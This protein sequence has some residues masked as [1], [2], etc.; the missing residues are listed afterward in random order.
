[1]S[2]NIPTIFAQQFSTNFQLLLQQKGSRLRGAGLTGSHQ[3]KQASPVDQFG[4]I[5]MQPV[6]G[7]FA[8]MGRVDASVDRRW[9]FP[10]DFDLPQLID[11]FDKL[12][13]LGDPASIYVQNAVNAA[14]RK[15]D[16]LMLAAANGTAK[17]GE[18]GATSTTLP[19]AQK[20][21]VAFGSAADV[22]LTV[23]KIREA[24]RILMK[25][26][27]D[28]DADPLYCA[29]GSDQNDNLLA[30]VQVISSDFNGGGS[31]PVLQD[32]RVMSFLS[33]N[34]IH[35]ELAV[36]N[37]VAGDAQINIWA[38]SGLYLGLWADIMTDVSTRK[39]L[40]GIPFQA[41]VMLSAGATRLE[42]AKMVQVTCNV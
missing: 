3:G 26:N 35:T 20:V 24:R 14:G 8:P 28:I 38:K 7:R 1:M 6:T 40:Q 41:Y 21:A 17:T 31:K 15:F 18:T 9:V 36:A 4:S 32:G 11:S 27:V 13:L 23:A 37:L 42:E 2:V 34:F 29:F 30:E 16:E 19:S 12:K 25:A 5:N 10:S 33:V 22:G 39:D